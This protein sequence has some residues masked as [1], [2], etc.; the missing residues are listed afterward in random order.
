MLKSINSIINGIHKWYIKEIAALDWKLTLAAPFVSMIIQG[1]ISKNKN[2][3]DMAL[4]EDGL[5][6][7]DILYEQYKDLLETSGKSN[8]EIYGVKLNTQDL[9]K[10]YE[11]IKKE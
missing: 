9:D 2:L 5:I 11:F 10:L 8:V 4:N 6:D 3:V 7:V 1:Y